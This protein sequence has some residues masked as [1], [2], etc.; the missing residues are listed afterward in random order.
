[1]TRDE[2]IRVGIGIFTLAEWHHRDHGQWCVC[3]EGE[4]LGAQ[5]AAVVDALAAEGLTFDSY[6]G[7]APGTIG[8]PR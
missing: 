7:T 2:A 5:S 1:M 4:Q 6:I 8:P 3:L